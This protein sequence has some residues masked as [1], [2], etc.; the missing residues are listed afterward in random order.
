MF[1]GR[2]TGS[3][4]ADGHKACANRR[5]VPFA[6]DT[7]YFLVLSSVCFLCPHL[8]RKHDHRSFAKPIQAKH[9]TIPLTVNALSLSGKNSNPAL[10]GIK[11]NPIGQSAPK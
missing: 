6:S 4:M 10:V 9:Y 11:I 5:C 1:F 3:S 2:E 7:P 8:L